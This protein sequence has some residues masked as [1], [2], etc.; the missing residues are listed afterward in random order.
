MTQNSFAKLDFST[1]WLDNLDHLGY[2]E[3]TAIQARALPLMLAGKDVVGKANTGTGKT[4]AFGLALLS[5]IEPASELPGALVLCPT[6]ELAAQVAEEIRRL[7]R[8]V[9]NTNVITVTGGASLDRQRRSLEHGVDVVVG[10]P[11]RL[12][13]HLRRE[14]LDL[15]NVETLVFDEADRMLDMGFFDD[16]AAIAEATPKQRQTLLFSATANDAVRELGERFQDDATL[17]SVADVESTPDITQILYELGD[18]DPMEALQRVLAHHDLDS[19]VIFCNQRDTTD[20]VADTLRKAGY[21]VDSLHGGMEQRDRDD[22]LLQFGN[23]SLRFLVA[24]NVAAR[25]IDIDE[26]DGVINYE[27]PRDPKEFIHRVGRTGR[28]GET[29]LAISLVGRYGHNKIDRIGGILEDVVPTSIETL[30]AAQATPRPAPMKTVVIRGG[31]KNKL[32]AGDIVGALTGE[33]NIDNDTIGL[34]T[35]GERVAF[36]AMERSVA[37]LACERIDAGKIKGRRFRAHMLG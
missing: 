28:A 26:I 30:P 23:G 7:A 16:V 11:G 13:D 34:I 36:V 14:S 21:S 1:A 4:A 35:I 37:E 15:S 3:M 9:A 12:L 2:V 6:R 22:V 27:L 32:R 17:I 33:L 10:T 24:T 25:G 5:K 8:P 19:A 18:A 20:M 31:R 29:G